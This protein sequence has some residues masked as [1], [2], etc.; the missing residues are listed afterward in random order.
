MVLRRRPQSL[1]ILSLASAKSIA[2]VAPGG[3]CVRSPPPLSG[4]WLGPSS[5]LPAYA[6]GCI[7]VA[8]ICWSLPRPLQSRGV[9]L[10]QTWN[11][12]RMTVGD[13]EL[14]IFSDGTYP[15]D[16]GAFFGV[17]PKVMW[18]RKV[19][20]DENNYVTAGLNSLLIRAGQQNVLVE[21]GMGNKLSERMVK[22]FGQPSQLLDNLSAGG[23]SPED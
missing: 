17:I 6:A 7:L 21:T 10:W 8:A 9:P 20:P 16:G 1:E 22:I 23:V 3:W 5:L 19:D 4:V 13:F 12:H 2:I 14:I 18:S 11:M 15:L